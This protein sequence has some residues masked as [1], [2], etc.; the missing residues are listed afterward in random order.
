MKSM[1]SIAKKMKKKFTGVYSNFDEEK[2]IAD[3]LSKL[4][5]SSRFA[6]DIAAGDGEDMS[7]TRK[8]FSQNWAGLAVELDEGKFAKL[9]KR[10][11]KFPLVS[12][13]RTRVNPDNIV[14]LLMGHN[15]A[16]DFGFL[17]L[18]IDGYDYYVLQSLLADF[19]PALIFAEINEKIPPPIKFT[20]KFDASYS[21]DESHFYGQSIS[22]LYELAKI[23]SYDLVH[24]E[25]NNAFLVP[26]R[27]N[28]LPALTPEAAYKS[29]Y[30]D[31]P[32]RKQ[33]FAYNAD[34][35]PLLT[36]PAEQAI[37][38]LNHTFSRHAGKFNCSI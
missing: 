24:L 5:I 35:E 13:A 15:I 14:S 11:R 16:K 6:V 19:Q 8:L 22:Q 28:T 27:I 3:I 29:G 2:I 25:Y 23:H 9:A 34:M 38:S 10:Y 17:S 32:D 21:W 1:F 36:M 26:R 12:L 31:R 4:R 7:N 18:D 37:A 33:R 30:V 20:V